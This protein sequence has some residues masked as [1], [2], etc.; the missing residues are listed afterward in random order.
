[1]VLAVV[2]SVLLSLGQV[3][4]VRGEGE[5]TGVT[6]SITVLKFNDA[7]GNGVRDNGEMGIEGWLIRLYTWV[8][9][10]M[11][12]VREGRTGPDGT[13]AFTDLPADPLWYKVW[14][15]PKA[16]WEP[17]APDN[18]G[19]WDG[20]YYVLED[21]YPDEHAFVSFG[22]VYTCAPLEACTPGYWKNLAQHADAW[23]AAGLD[24]EA[25]FDATFG[26]NYF[27]PD[28]TLYDAVWANG[29]GLAKVARFGTAAL[30]S[31]LHPDVHFALS[32]GEVIALVQARDGD[33]LGNLF[34]DDATCPID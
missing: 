1:M 24:A 32:P 28:I 5:P 17:S 13:V 33:A 15:E 22:N 25:D 7:N 4:L 27:S 2:L 11:Q 34:P 19:W 12:V 16:C 20:G 23:A 21:L 9:N 30:L 10:T 29:G 26:V 18:L 6:G 31:A 3:G 14:E 8:G